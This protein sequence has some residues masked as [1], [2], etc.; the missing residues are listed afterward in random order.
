VAGTATG[1]AKPSKCT[2]N[3]PAVAVDNNWQWGSTGSWGLPGQQ[4]KYM[5]KVVNNDLGC[6]PSSFVIGLSAPSGF[7][8]SIPTNTISLKPTT[9]GY[10]SAYVT[11]PSVIA[12]GDYP[13]TATVTR[14]GSSD[15][16]SF[17]SYYKVYTSD[18]VAPTLYWPN[19]GDG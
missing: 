19:P 17:T 13:L 9:S 5:I 1:A 8:V 12:D 6:S 16:G 11:S 7:S 2:R 15:S 18:T 14:A 10:L 4:L 3:A